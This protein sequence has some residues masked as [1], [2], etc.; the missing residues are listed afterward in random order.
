MDNLEFETLTDIKTLL[1]DQKCFFNTGKTKDIG[2]R[3]EIQTFR[4]ALLEKKF[5]LFVRLCSVGIGSISGICRGEIQ[6]THTAS[7]FQ[8]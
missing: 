2:F 5:K 6:V 8:R 3:K 7:G 4:K 1:A